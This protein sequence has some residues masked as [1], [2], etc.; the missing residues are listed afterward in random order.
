MIKEIG[1]A[2]PTS[3]IGGKDG[4]WYVAVKASDLL[5]TTAKTVV[6]KSATEAE[7]RAFAETLPHP[8]GKYSR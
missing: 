2:F 8:F 4:C 1:S 6:Y 5:P 3:A 7:A